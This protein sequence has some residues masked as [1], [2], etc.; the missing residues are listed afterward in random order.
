MRLGDGRG[1]TALRISIL[2]RFHVIPVLV[3]RNAT[4]SGNALPES[5]RIHVTAKKGGK[6]TAHADTFVAAVYA[7]GLSSARSRGLYAR[8]PSLSK[9]NVVE[10]FRAGIKPP[11]TSARRSVQTL[12]KVGDPL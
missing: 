4:N 6:N 8:V 9:Q 2:I 10:F 7:L 11:A 1:P 5:A 3:L 12:G